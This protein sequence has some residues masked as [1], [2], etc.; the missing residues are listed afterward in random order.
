M[1]GNKNS[2]YYILTCWLHV[3]LVYEECNAGT[4]LQDLHISPRNRSTSHSY[5]RWWLTEW[6]ISIW[7]WTFMVPIHLGLKNRPFVPHNLVPVLGN[8]V[9]LLKFQM[10]PRLKLLMT[11]GS[12][13]EPRYTCLSEAKAS[14]LQRMWAEVSSSAPRLLDKGLLVNPIKW[15]CLIRVLCPVSRSITTLEYILL[16]DKSLV[17]AAGLGPEIN[18]RV[19]LWVLLRSCHLAKWYLSIQ[20]FIFHL[21]SCLQTPKNGPGPTHFW[22][23]PALASLS[24][25]L[26]PHT[27]TCPGI[28]YSPTVCW[29]EISFNTFRHCCTSIEDDDYNGWQNVGTGLTQ[30]SRK[31]KSQGYICKGKAVKT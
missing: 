2:K 30:H 13:K 11:S 12:K 26:F 31:V 9:P 27:P 29:A 20:C 19:C 18:S 28:Q 6:L 10:V 17:Y 22:T 3:C 1:L 5:W 25:I 8:P 7:V 21:V 15:R 14:H 24:S 4:L 16:K 23:E